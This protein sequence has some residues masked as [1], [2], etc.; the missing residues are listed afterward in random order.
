LSLVQ[1]LEIPELKKTFKEGNVVPVRLFDILPSDMTKVIELT[2]DPADMKGEET[3]YVFLSHTW[4]RPICELLQY[5]DVD[6]WFWIDV[7]SVLQF[8]GED[9]VCM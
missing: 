3:D 4:K 7:V 2:A 9:Q 1:P 6:R 8:K 5:V